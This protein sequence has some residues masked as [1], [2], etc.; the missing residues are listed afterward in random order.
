MDLHKIL[1]DLG[2]TYLPE[3]Y[4]MRLVVKTIPKS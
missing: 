4:K 3:G 1:Q 2:D